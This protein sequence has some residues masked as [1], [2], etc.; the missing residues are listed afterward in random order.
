[1]WKNV[2]TSD[3]YLRASQQRVKYD[4]KKLIV[5]AFVIKEWRGACV[6]YRRRHKKK[7]FIL[8]YCNK[9]ECLASG[10]DSVRC[11]IYH[12]RECYYD[13]PRFKMYLLVSG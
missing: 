13:D 4:K 3:N 9:N 6:E 10:E 11:N 1:M 2:K 7:A 5:R 8:L 12:T